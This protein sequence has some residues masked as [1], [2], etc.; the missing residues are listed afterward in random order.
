MSGSTA[1]EIIVF[2]QRKQIKKGRLRLT[3]LFY[4]EITVCRRLNADLYLQFDQD[5]LR[6]A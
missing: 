1:Q 6:Q 5:L 2:T 3:F 4:E